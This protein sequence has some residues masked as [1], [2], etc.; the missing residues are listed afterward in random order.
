VATPVYLVRHAK[1]G[2]REQWDGADEER[3]LTPEG[4]RQAE[5]LVDLFADAAFTRLVSSPYVRCV[6]TFE[7]L[8]KARGL[9]VETDDALAEGAP[10]EETLG[11][12]LTA[13]APVALCTHGDIEQNVLDELLEEGVPLDGPLELKKGS[14]WIL[15]V[16]GREI[17]RARYVAPP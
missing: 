11:L 16:T 4:W 8:A 13:R 14:T 5:A 3:P 12:V 9:P 7:P 6:Q 2:H 10:V 17:V 15:D 1:A